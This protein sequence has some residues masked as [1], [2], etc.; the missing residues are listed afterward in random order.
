MIRW[1]SVLLVLLVVASL[2]ASGCARSTGSV[3]IRSEPPG[4]A[5]SIDGMDN[6]TAPVQIA[7]W[8]PGE[9]AV[10]ARMRGYRNSAVTLSLGPGASDP[11]TLVLKPIPIPEDRQYATI[12]DLGS[13]TT[14]RIVYYGALRTGTE[15]PAIDRVQFVMGKTENEDP[16]PFPLDGAKLVLVA[17]DR[18]IELAQDSPLVGPETDPAPGT[19]RVVDAINTGPDSAVRAN[20]QVKIVGKMPPDRTLPGEGRLVVEV[21]P[22]RGPS[23]LVNWR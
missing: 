1:C 16:E 20:T 12:K 5:I 4:A 2:F 18:M 13:G 23:V 11:V 17:D 6:G 8:P 22:V 14:R 7:D 19:W 3:T 15:G 21:K 9:Y 10:E